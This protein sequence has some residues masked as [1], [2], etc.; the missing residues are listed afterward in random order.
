MLSINRILVI[1]SI[2]LLSFPGLAQDPYAINFSTENGLPSNTVYDIFEDKKGFIWIASD[3]GLTRYDGFEFKTFTCDEQTSRAGSNLFE[4]PLGRIW[5]QNF[6]GFLFYVKDEKMHTLPHQKPL[7]YFPAGIIR[8]HLFIVQQG[9]I[10]LYD[11]HSFRRKIKIRNNYLINTQQTKDAF[12]VISNEIYSLDYNGKETFYRNPKFT[13]SRMPS[14]MARGKDKYWMIEKSE[15]PKACYTL[16]KK[17]FQTSFKLNNTSY[18][19]NLCYSPSNLWL[20]TTDGV[21]RY[22]EVNPKSGYKHYFQGKN[23]SC[24]LQDKAGNHW[25]GT[26]NNGILFVPDLKRKLLF[27]EKHPRKVVVHGDHIYMSTYDDCLYRVD[28]INNQSYLLF[29]GNTNHAI[30]LLCHSPSLKQLFLTSN[31]FSILNESGKRTANIR[32]AVKD[33]RLLDNNYIA[34]AASGICCIYQI[35]PNSKSIWESGYYS[36]RQYVDS[37]YI[38]IQVAA[39]RGKSVEFS[40]ANKHIYFATNLGLYKIS[41]AGKKEIV[42]RKKP[43]YISSLSYYNKNIYALSNSGKILRIDP[44]DSVTNLSESLRLSEEIIQFMTISDHRLLLCSQNSV[45]IYE[46]KNGLRKVIEIPTYISEVTDLAIWH[47]QLLVTSERGILLLPLKSNPLQKRRGNLVINHIQINGKQVYQSHT[48]PVLSHLQND[49]EINY[50][51]LNF[52]QTGETSLR[53]RINSG[54]W[55][56]A[57]DNSRTLKFAS[58]S[59]GN[60]TIKFQLEGN[61]SVHKI[62]FT[63]NKPWYQQ[64]WFISALL[65][66]LFGSAFFFFRWRI[67]KLQL[68]NKLLS[69]KIELEESLTQS[70]LTSIKSQMNPHFF[71]NALNTIQYFIFTNDRQNASTYL[72]KFSK[73]TRMILEMS[74]KEHVILREEINALT[75]YLDIEKVRFDGDFEYTINVDEHTDPDLI[76]IPSMLIQPYVENAIKH[77]LLHKKGQKTLQISICRSTAGLEIT[78]DDNGIGRAM[79]NE[80]NKKKNEHHRPFATSANQKRIELLNKGRNTVVGV[81]Y[82][83]KTKDGRPEGTTVIITIPINT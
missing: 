52:N 15:H 75:L 82:T 83:D 11:M 56:T 32:M 53:Y 50:S 37:N 59:P 5:Y 1:F 22:N 2:S 51:I 7:G 8:D 61:P 39:V 76:R 47:N 18:L 12:F 57:N 68:R 6:D 14:L 71:Y 27:S 13:P 62:Q 67:R 38:W 40:P 36:N 72:S 16:Q 63:I 20:C 35:S 9:Y 21:F 70:M 19:Q 49:I 10:A 46:L 34:L 55:N 23:I 81:H 79:A 41:K 3:A 60:Y 4:D 54:A 25:F 43:L 45:H 69:E 30:N 66:L 17:H 80:L 74:D 77:G 58:L 28:P 24:V 33:C 29:K 48:I 73:L 64:I 44:K 78:I 65:L 26:Q 42:S 31:H